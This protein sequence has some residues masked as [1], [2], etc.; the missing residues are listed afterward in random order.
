MKFVAEFDISFTEEELSKFSELAKEWNKDFPETVRQCMNEKCDEY[1]DMFR[2][3]V[4]DKNEA[5]K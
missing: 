3:N 5:S 1:L 4:P 2:N